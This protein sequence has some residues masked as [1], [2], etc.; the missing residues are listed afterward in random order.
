[1]AGAY[2]EVLMRHLTLATAAFLTF[3]AALAAQADSA[4]TNL[5]SYAKAFHLA[6]TRPRLAQPAYVWTAPIAE[7]RPPPGYETLHEAVLYRAQRFAKAET[8]YFQFLGV[9]L[10]TCPNG[11][12]SYGCG[13]PARVTSPDATMLRVEYWD[14]SSRFTRVVKA[15]NT[16]LKKD[17]EVSHAPQS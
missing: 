4:S 15:V 16:R 14:A 2:L 12:F 6:T 10:A 3:P 13:I 11:P 8:Q 5:A 7:L 9:D 1:V 17:L